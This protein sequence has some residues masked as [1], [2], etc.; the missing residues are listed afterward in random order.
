MN[1]TL[2]KI[3]SVLALVA[4]VVAI[5]FVL[6]ART[7]DAAPDVSTGL[8]PVP[9]DSGQPQTGGPTDPGSSS[10]APADTGDDEDEPAFGTRFDIAMPDGSVFKIN[11]DEAVFSHEEQELGDYFSGKDSDTGTFFIEICFLEGHDAAATAPGFLD[12]YIE[13]IEF[14]NSGLDTIGTSKVIGEAISATDGA[15]T[16][17]AWL[18]DIDGGVIAVIAGYSTLQQQAAAYQS[19]G[20]IRLTD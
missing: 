20:S 12:N 13:Y 16:V 9:S 1:K 7:K 19:L 18:I 17:E 10:D 15:R 3:I 4:V 5:F 6:Q 14:E 2:Q 8:P 11:V